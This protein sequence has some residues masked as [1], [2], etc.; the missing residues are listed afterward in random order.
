MAAGALLFDSKGKLLVVKPN[1]KDYWSIPGGVI[2]KNESPR[3][4]CF[5]EIKEEIGMEV[6]NL[7]FLC[8]DYKEDIDRG[9]N[10]QFTFISKISDGKITLQDDELDDY[11]FVD[12]EEALELIGGGLRKRLPTCFEAIDNNKAIYIENGE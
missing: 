12:R 6:G 10:L 1:Y 11:K 2:E 4:G 9:D 7:E 3:A 5:R 8:V